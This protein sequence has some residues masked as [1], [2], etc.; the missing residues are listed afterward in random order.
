MWPSTGSLRGVNSAVERELGLVRRL[1]EELARPVKLME[2]CGTHTMA[3]SRS[4]LRP[5]LPPAVRLLSGPGCPVCVTPVDYVDRAVA[6][7]M[8]PCVTVATFGDM[9]RV[10]GSVRSL[11]EAR[12]EGGR[13]EVV[14]S[15]LDALDMAER[16]GSRRVVFLGVG[17][18]TTAPGIAWT[19]REAA[20]R[21]VGNYHVLSGHKVMPPPMEALAG[22]PDLRI[23]GFICPGHVSVV[24]GW[25]AYEPLAA[26]HGVPCVV[27]GFEAADVL[28]ATARLLG[29]IRDGRAEVENGY[30]R[31]VSRE[32][33]AAAQALL[34]DVFEPAD[35]A[36]RGLGTIPGSGLAIRERY[37]AQ[38][39]ERAFPDLDLPPPVEPAGCRCGEVLKGCILPPD[40]PL[41]G[42]R[43]TP[44][45]PVGA[46]MVSS[47]GACAAY[48]RFERRAG[49]A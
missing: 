32:G 8:R 34:A 2:V 19:I 33:N 29:Q 5:L 48:Y 21:G 1:A 3:V 17:F 4:G 7:A 9:V 38:D 36:W 28:A 20:R 35:A 43:C 30:T 42:A 6:L 23:D 47:E 27:A 11:E 41:F 26:R 40:C 18:E 49:A 31:S 15:A 13:V 16:N 45:R 46:C 24:I 12:A 22:A 39:A 14:Y 25:G 44:A 10:P 37:A